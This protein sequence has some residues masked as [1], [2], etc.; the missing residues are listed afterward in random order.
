MERE[1][2]FE[3]KRLILE[4]CFYGGYKELEKGMERSLP[5][6]FLVNVGNLIRD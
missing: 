3:Q 1:K 6:L 4:K 5:L 2:A